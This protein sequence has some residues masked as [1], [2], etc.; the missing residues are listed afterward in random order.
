MY[1]HPLLESLQVC[2]Q[3]PIYVFDHTFKLI[4]IFPLK[5]RGG[6]LS[7]RV[8]EYLKNSLSNISYQDGTFSLFSFDE[9]CFM[10]IYH[11]QNYYFIF[12]PFQSKSSIKK[13][14]ILSKNCQAPKRYL[15][16][17]NSNIPE[18]KDVNHLL[19]LIHYFFTGHVYFLDNEQDQ[20]NLEILEDID[21]S[22]SEN[23]IE[24]SSLNKNNQFNYEV[25]LLESVKKGDLNKVK[26][27]LKQGLNSNKQLRDSR[28]EK[29]YSILIFEKLS[30]LAIIMGVSSH[31]AHHT[32][33][34]YIEKLEACQTVHEVLLLRESAIILFT[35]KIGHINNYSYTIARVLRYIQE[36]IS[37]RLVIEK[38]A[39]EFHFSESNLR[40][41]F[42]KE[43]SCS[44]QQYIRKLK[45][46]QAKIMLRNGKSVT[47][48]SA[49]LGYSDAAHFSKSFKELVGM[50]PK[51]YQQSPIKDIR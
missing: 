15:K 24:H 30:Q 13:L 18:V 36:N 38:I 40:K 37:Q 39:K 44:I 48:V 20:L 49:N 26:S 50:S 12:G 45:I 5:K 2:L 8:I 47:K 51:H 23:F 1:R 11:F 21:K 3:L 28:I 25:E 34:Y 9:D 27:F 19:H 43:M 17:K 35:Q 29:N 6:E 33:D 4:C 31:L 7:H 41:L 22:I 46:D 32:R 16:I 10:A 14:C 42:K